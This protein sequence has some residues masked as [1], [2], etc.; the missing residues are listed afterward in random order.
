[1]ALAMSGWAISAWG[2]AVIAV[3]LGAWAL[4]GDRAKGR[5]RCPRCW[6]DMDGAGQRCPECGHEARS[7][8]RLLKARRRWRWAFVAAVLGAAAAGMGVTSVVRAHGWYALAPDAVLVWWIDHANPKS[9]AEA[10]RFRAALAEFDRRAATGGFTERQMERLAERAFGPVD[11]DAALHVREVVLADQPLAFYIDTT[12]RHYPRPWRVAVV[13][14]PVGNPA[15]MFADGSS[16]GWQTP[17][18]D[19]VFGMSFWGKYVTY[20]T[21]S[22]GAG[23]HDMTFEI[24]VIDSPISRPG[25]FGPNL[26][27]AAW[28]AVVTRAITTVP[29]LEEAIAPAAGAG[30]DAWV[31]QNLTVETNGLN[32]QA[33]FHDDKEFPGVTVAIRTELLLDAEVVGTN[34][35][36]VR[37]VTPHAMGVYSAVVEGD[38]GVL[39]TFNAAD[40]RWTVRITGDGA[41]ALRDV[42]STEFWAGSFEMPASEAA[43]QP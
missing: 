6:Y 13:V 17:L 39:A 25:E 28:T 19:G 36:L 12:F 22:R 8:R 40:P 2:L 30:I 23:S 31:R 37:S 33:D 24:L 42:D 3:A 9:P 16:T 4:W 32:V 41:W 21:P 1:M 20:R 34:R 38:S 15:G 7:A 43:G 27:G 18:G 11:W 35:R 5:R 14:K 10:E 29:T 26:R